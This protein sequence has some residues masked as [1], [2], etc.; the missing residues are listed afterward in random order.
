M[1]IA[2]STL[3]CKINQFDT[4]AMK[5]KLRSEDCTLVPFEEKADVYII[6]TCT[7]TKKSDYQSRQLI[8]RAKNNNPL[9][10]IVVTG[11]YAQVNPS[12]IGRMQEVDLILGNM[13][14]EDVIDYVNNIIGAV[15]EPPLQKSVFVGDV[16]LQTRFRYA[17]V[18]R[19]SD[20]TRA[21]LKI[22][23]GCSARCSYCIVPLARG[24][25]RSAE[26]QEIIKQIEDLTASGYQEVVLIGVHLGTYGKDLNPFINLTC[27]LKEILEKT[28]IERI[29]LSSIE[30]MD[31]PDG[32]IDLMASSDRICR[33]LHIPLQSGS[34]RVL[35]AMNRGYTPK[36]YS[37]LILRVE[38]TIKGIGIGAD[39]IAG[40][41]GE[42][43]DDFLATIKLIE[44]LPISYFH[45]FPY[46]SRP[47]TIA[48]TMGG[49]IPE[50][51]KKERCQRLRELGIKK[52]L[53]FKKQHIGLTLKVLIEEEEDK[54]TGLLRGLSDNYLRILLEGED[55]LKNKIV[56]VIME[57]VEGDKL[58]ATILNDP[59]PKLN[60]LNLL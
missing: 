52:N 38:R 29:R 60:L 56:E 34:I 36:D 41:P 50:K 32:L 58:I 33:H 21:F 15:C 8:R 14:K 23:D 57:G 45:I 9:A 30:P 55:S 4:A 53:E 17:W 59:S 46:S 54:E 16:S 7:V 26:S 20:R 48:A 42:E 28:S 6:N 27:L 40:F 37:D 25:N 22:Q 11:C 3:G 47:G 35:R 2:F 49:Q 10:R 31:I 51:V 18:K 19:F 1:R 43:K 44:E 5:E 13:E 24:P 39:I 12:E